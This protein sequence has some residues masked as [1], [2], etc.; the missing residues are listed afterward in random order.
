MTKAIGRLIHHD[1]IGGILLVSMAA[2]ALCIANS[3]VSHL[4]SSFLDIPVS[5]S[6]G[7]FAIDK[8]LLLWIND[9]LMAVYFFLIGL[10]V[11]REILDGQLRSKDQIILPGIAA[12]AGIAFPAMFFLA[13]NYGNSTT[14]NGWAIIQTKPTALFGFC[15]AVHYF[16]PLLSSNEL[17][18]YPCIYQAPNGSSASLYY[19][20]LVFLPVRIINVII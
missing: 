4:Y 12:T 6:I 2:L 3:P 13:L 16:T 11:K 18:T 7:S 10:E 19:G 5:L 8:P 9:G 15:S 20:V 14:I 17:N 1:A